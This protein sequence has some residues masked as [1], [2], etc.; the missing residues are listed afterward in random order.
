MG[1]VHDAKGN[2]RTGGEDLGVPS[3]VAYL[4]SLGAE[5]EDIHHQNICEIEIRY[6]EAKTEIRELLRAAYPETFAGRW[7]DTQSGS[8]Q[9]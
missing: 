8:L 9:P 6:K 5:G 7:M 1:D 2:R 3:M 4:I